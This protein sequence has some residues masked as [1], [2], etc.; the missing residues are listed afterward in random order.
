[1]ISFVILS[2]LGWSLFYPK[3]LIFATIRLLSCWLC[4]SPHSIPHNFASVKIIWLKFAETRMRTH[5]G[6]SQSIHQLSTRFIHSFQ[7]KNQ[8]E[9]YNNLN[10]LLFHS[11]MLQPA[12]QSL[13]WDTTLAHV[14]ITIAAS[15]INQLQA[16][17]NSHIDQMQTFQQTIIYTMQLDLQ[18]KK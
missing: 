15:N 10:S 11:W 2:F 7:N 13:W 1:M 18:K 17:N 4:T 5:N 16:T 12:R 6:N 9:V 3:I 14:K 8:R